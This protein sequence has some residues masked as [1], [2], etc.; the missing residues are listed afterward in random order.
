MCRRQWMREQGDF[1]HRRVVRV[2]T[3]K[4][5]VPKG[6]PTGHR[7]HGSVWAISIVRNEA[8]V[9]G[10]TLQHHLRQGV[11]AILI[12]DNGSTDGTLD[13]L[14]EFARDHPV[15]VLS[16]TW[17]VWDQAV[18]TT[19]LANIARR[20]GADWIM[21][22]DADEFWFAPGA[23]AAEHLRRSEATVAYAQIHN[24]FPLD[25]SAGQ[26]SVDKP[27]RF[28]LTPHA[29]KKVAFRSHPMASVQAGNHYVFRSGPREA[30]LRIAHLPWRSHE[31]MRQKVTQGSVA[32]AIQ[33]TVGRGEP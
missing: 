29:L 11:E 6:L 9:V 17:P 27:F 16:D 2:A 25:A 7:R 22:F 28:D 23:S 3:D 5:L 13:I 30:G 31:Q 14:H 4:L 32:T 12:A 15:Y 24:L 10:L 19:L 18:K 8:D 20:A 26:L 21:P 1:D 33:R